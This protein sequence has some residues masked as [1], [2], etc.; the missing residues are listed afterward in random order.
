MVHLVIC[1]R[2]VCPDVCAISTLSSSPDVCAISTLSSSPDV[3]HISS[4]LL[5]DTIFPNSQFY[6]H[7]EVFNDKCLHI[8]NQIHKV[9][10]VDGLIY[11]HINIRSLLPKIDEIRYIVTSI[12][13]DCLS[14]N[15]S[16]LSSSIS[17]SE[18]EI[19]GFYVFR[20]DRNRNGGGVVLYVKDYLSPHVICKNFH[21]H[22]VWVDI[23]VKNVHFTIGSIYRPPNAPVS[24]FDLIISDLETISSLSTNVII[25]GDLNFNCFDKHSEKYSANVNISSLENMFQ[26]NQIIREPTR[27]TP[28]SSTLLDFIFCSDH[29]HP[30]L[31]GVHHINL[32][33]HYAVFVVI[34]CKKPHK[35]PNIIKHRN[36]KKFNFTNF[37]CHLYNSHVLNSCL[38]IT[39]IHNAWNVWKKEYVAICNK[40]A[41][42][43]RASN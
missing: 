26:L 31:S 13:I 34:P 30:V 8:N 43:S 38:N 5:S 27:V 1:R 40:H 24:Y 41:P 22:S 20:N 4:S 23:K 33:D 3:N 32:S 29:I 42:Y 17:D 21:S 6:E 35:P 19:P 16:M 25:M 36:F 12:N 37:I 18:V 10:N 15:E 9:K 7:N 28:V 11:F 2:T 39:D 14:I